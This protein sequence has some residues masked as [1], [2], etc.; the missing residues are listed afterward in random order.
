MISR[1]DPYVADWRSAARSLMDGILADRVE[2]LGG[3]GNQT[4]TRCTCWP[5]VAQDFSLAGPCTAHTFPHV[6][7]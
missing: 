3:E 1:D 4:G 2:V 6:K 7:T 5:F